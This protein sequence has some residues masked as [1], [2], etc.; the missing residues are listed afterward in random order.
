MNKMNTSIKEINR[1]DKM[2]REWKKK[3]LKSKLT[4]MT[5]ICNDEQ[6]QENEQKC[7]K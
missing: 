3:T 6:K 7:N 2:M 1:H 4:Q 5:N